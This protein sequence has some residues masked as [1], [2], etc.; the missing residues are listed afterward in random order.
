MDGIIAQE[1]VDHIISFLHDSPADWPACALVC[2][3][4]VHCAQSHI[5]KHIRFISGHSADE[6]RWDRV[7]QTFYASP[8][9]IRHVR[10]L[11]ISNHEVSTKTFLAICNFPFTHLEGA[12]VQLDFP[13]PSSTLAVQQLLSLS[14]LRRMQ[15]ICGR[16]LPDLWQIWDRCSHSLRHLDLGYHPTS[17]PD[18]R[19]AKHS[20]S[21]IRLE[22]LKLRVEPSV[23]LPLSV[24]TATEFLGSK[25]FAPT[26][27]T[28]QILDLTKPP[29]DM[30]SF[31][32]FI[33]LRIFVLPKSF[34][35]VSA[36]LSTF[37]ASA[38]I[39]KIIL[40]GNYYDNIPAHQI[41]S[42]L[43]GVPGSPIVEFER[44][45]PHR[46]I[47]EDLPLLRSKD[48]LRRT[49][50][51]GDWFEAPHL[52]TTGF[53]PQPSPALFLVLV[54][55]TAQ[56][57]TSFISF[58]TL[59]I[60]TGG[61]EPW[62]WLMIITGILTLITSTCFCAWFLT[63]QERRCSYAAQVSQES[64]TGVE[65]K[66]FKK[67]H[68]QA[69]LIV[70]SFGFTVFRTT[71]LGCV[72]GITETITIWTGV[73]IAARM[74]SLYRQHNGSF[75][76]QEKYKPRNRVPWI[77]ISVCYVA[78]MLLVLVIRYLLIAENKRR[79]AKPVQEDEYDDVFIER[80]AKDGSDVMKKIKINYSP[81]V[82]DSLRRF[83]RA[84][85]PL[86]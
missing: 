45:T 43:F 49:H 52:R 25:T 86:L 16:D 1:L 42:T 64:Q 47:T 46:E 71:L 8:H 77:V 69:P 29:L 76:W 56:I 7:Q 63:P 3:P 24:H 31:P 81:C 58:G 9:L 14:T 68:N 33:L 38:R 11:D 75:M 22:S 4:W 21:S 13:N 85:A 65:N 28:I 5:F 39:P 53:F 82:T 61:F 59:H 67:E 62:Q 35:W 51:D 10:L 83:R 23:P 54:D 79:D 32:S 66:H 48:L 55:G 60:K 27:Q 12:S 6:R 74:G 37:M 50:Y 78:C 41:D 40:L 17:S 70:S 20:S 18:F 84:A 36:T 26:L 15:I 57:I 2:R 72:P 80:L 34:P 44:F 73:T 19:P 30:S